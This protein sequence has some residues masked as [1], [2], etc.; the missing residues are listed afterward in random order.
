ETWPIFR[1]GAALVVV[2]G[3][4][5]A[6][7]LWPR[8]RSVASWAV[9]A[10][11]LAGVFLSWK[12]GFTR[13]DGHVLI[14][15]IFAVLL[16]TGMPVVMR[17]ATGR[18]PAAIALAL[19]LHGIWLAAPAFLQVSHVW[20]RDR[21]V[22]TAS[23]LTGRTPWRDQLAAAASQAAEAI[24]LPNVKAVVG[25]STVDLID[26]SQGF[27][28]LNG[29]NYHPRP[30]PQSYVAYTPSL[31]RANLAF[32]ESEEAPAFV[33]VVA[34]AVDNRYLGLT[35]SLVLAE[36]PRRYEVVLEEPYHIVLQRRAVQ[37]PPASQVLT[38][39]LSVSVRPGEAVELPDE[40]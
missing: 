5:I 26:F 20:A 27:L 14:F 11:I 24:R 13:A 22:D 36:L 19:A 38:P 3:I 30:V 15:F 31:L 32:Y 10:V 34:A 4:W 33:V 28:I 12:H 37:P 1:A 40:P 8:R 39:L 7:W 18:V 23:R 29:F 25:E 2:F 35:D 6:A 21:A 9:A 16:S 17:G